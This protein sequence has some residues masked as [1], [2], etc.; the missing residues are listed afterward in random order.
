METPEKKLSILDF[1]EPE[2]DTTQV[3]YSKDKVRIDRN[4]KEYGDRKRIKP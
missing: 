4:Q 1:L 2:D 3:Y